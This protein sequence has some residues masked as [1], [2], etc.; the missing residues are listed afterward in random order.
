MV[1]LGKQVRE[2]ILVQ[3]VLRVILALMG[4]MVKLD[5]QVPKV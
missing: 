5:I 2:E 4:L 1:Q 3:K